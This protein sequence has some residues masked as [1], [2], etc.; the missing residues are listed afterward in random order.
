M[1][2]AHPT[3]A[4]LLADIVEPNFMVASSTTTTVHAIVLLIAT[5]VTEERGTM[6]YIW[7]RVMRKACEKS[8]VKS[9]FP[10]VGV[11]ICSSPLSNFS[12]LSVCSSSDLVLIMK[13]VM[14]RCTL[15][16]IWF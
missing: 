12:I 13:G 16:L 8:C 4:N 15:I 6:N 3:E 9:I 14:K 1:P 11:S 5:V 2:S 7:W 10:F